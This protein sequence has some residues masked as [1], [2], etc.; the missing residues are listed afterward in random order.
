MFL[1]IFSFELKYRLRRPATYIYFALL[2][3]LGF[4][5]INIMGGA[6][7]G[8]SVTTGSKV[9]VNS[10]ASLAPVILAISFVAVL[11]I[12]AIMGNAVYRDFE[13]RTHALLYTTPIKKWEY[14]GGRFA[15]SLV[16][17]M[18]VLLGIGLGLMLGELPLPWLEQ[19]KFGPFNFMAYLQPY[20]LI[21]WPNMLFIGAIFFTLATL[22][23]SVLSTYIGS[24]IFLVLYSISQNFTQDLDN[25]FLVTLLDPM[26]SAAIEFTT[27]YWTV[28]EQ[29]NNLLP[30]N[31]EIVLNRA[32]WLSVGLAILAFCYF[33]FSFSFFASEGKVNRKRT[34]EKSQVATVTRFLLPET[35]PTYTGLQSLNQYFRLVKLEFLGVVKSVYF[36]AIV[37]A[38]VTALLA[39]GAQVGKMYDT[40]TFP[41]TSEIMDGLTG[42]FYLFQL[43]II[44]YYAGELVW[45]ER[46]HQMNQIYDALP[47][48]NWVPFASKLSALMLIQVVLMVMVMV[49]GM[50]VQTFKGY[51]NF[52]PLLYI[53]GLFGLKLIG[54]LLLCVLA[55]LIQVVVNNKYLGHFIMAGYYLFTLF[56]GQMGIEHNLLRFNSSPGVEY[57]A[58][59]GYGHFIGPFVLFKLYWGAFAILLALVANAL[60]VRGTET[61]LKWRLKVARTQFSR[62]AGLVSALALLVFLTSGGFIFYNTNVLNEYTSGKQAQKEQADYEKKYKKYDGRPQ[63]RIVASNLNVDIFP[64]ERNFR[65]KGH[66]WLKNKTKVAIDSI[67]VNTNTEMDI[68]K[69][70]FSRSY[71]NVFRDKKTGYYIYR[72]NQPLQPGDSLKLVMDLVH[73]TKGFEN[74]GSNTNIV[75]N[76]SF[77]NSSYLPSIGYNPEAEITDEAT[78][79]EYGL[80]P[81]E[82][83]ASVY[84]TA[85]YGNTYLSHDSDWIDFEATVSTVPTQIAIAPGYLQKEWIANGRRYFHYK[86]DSKILNFYSFLSADYQV[87]KDKWNDVTV[88]IYYHKGH[89]YNLDRMIKGVKASLDY[90]TR[91]FG[92]YQHRQVRILEFP[93]YA[94]FAQSFPN[95]IPFSESIGFIADIDDED[96]EDVD[97]PFYV[98]AHEVAHQWW[99]HQVIGA[100]VQGGTLLS[101][102][103]S[104][105]SALM[106]MKK[107]YGADRMQKFLRYEMDRYL[108]GRTYESLKEQPLYKVENQQYIHYRK[109]S[110]I[111]YALADFLGEEK[112]N[113]ALKEYVQKVKFQEAPYTTSVEFLSYIKKATPD[114]LQYLVADM[115][116]NITLYENKA[117]ELTYQQMKDGRYKVT[118]NLDAKKYYADSLGNEK[119]AKMNDLV[120][121]AVFT[122][123]KEK[124][125]TKGKDVPV[126]FEKKRL[127]TGQNK[128]EI[129]V[130]EK[131]S[132]AGIDPYNKLIDRTPGDNLKS[133]TKV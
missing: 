77:F 119:E 4:L 131:P 40:N 3:L 122:Y 22:T 99:A 129:I 29:N 71:K 109:G 31:L 37:F 79:K 78:R 36:I 127:K 8:A 76:G 17:T 68:K 39:F 80:K 61:L 12:S 44:I 75:Y 91:N 30:L 10:P 112:L 28:A 27:K 86:M 51:Y 46:D 116:E 13:H 89:E 16:I 98:T 96:E 125:A 105:Y 83:M 81:K 15:G 69:L 95:T 38:G 5:F 19:E 104:Q 23:R 128:F 92:P 85:A 107:T 73:E 94:S 24:I 110:V 48:P 82:R 74:S 1:E 111:M 88:E 50:I 54:M 67:H 102:T 52:E 11:I 113:A 120:D 45:R 117:D 72:L 58:M 49:C 130:N 43:I 21:V 25:Q 70:G 42:S 126:Y 53:K 103:M 100:N 7:K 20:L 63:P 93:G 65:F 47:I 108:S 87:K 56:Q 133:V 6:F 59:N 14:L 64:E 84:D 106:V 115:F 101:E 121:V 55:M 90:Y 132:K 32:I 123:K 124:G 18:L 2:F 114:S 35:H 60:W 62:S 26:G 34:T 118:L 57:S 41:V 33:R 66:F 9:L 97:Y